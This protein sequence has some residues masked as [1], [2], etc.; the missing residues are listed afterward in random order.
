MEVGWV[1]EEA[2]III[3]RAYIQQGNGV[4]TVVNGRS[5]SLH[6]HGDLLYLITPIKCSVPPRLL[7]LCDSL[8]CG[9]YGTFC[10]GISWNAMPPPSIPNQLEASICSSYDLAS[11][12]TRYVLHCL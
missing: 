1:E 11:Q 6:T 2:G 8:R 12:V 5:A 7:V 3:Q 9:A 10:Y 4:E